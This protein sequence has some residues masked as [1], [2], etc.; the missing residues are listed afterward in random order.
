MIADCGFGRE[1]VAE[2]AQPAMESLAVLPQV[3]ALVAACISLR[4]EVAAVA[5]TLGGKRR[6]EDI[7]AADEAQHLE[8][9]MVR[10][11]EAADRADRLG[12]GADDEVDIALAAHFL[13]HAAA[14]GAEEAHAMRFVAQDHRAML[15]G[16]RDH[17]RQRRDVAEH[18]IDAFEHD[19]LAG[20]L[21]Q[22]AEALVEILDAVVAEADDLGIAEPAA[23][24]DRR[25]AVGVEDDVIALAGKR[26]DHAEIGLVAGRKDDRRFGAVKFLQRI[27]DN[28]DADRRCR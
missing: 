27:L 8:I 16:D 13:I 4:I 2:L 28:R 23:V 15:L 25:V 1:R 9:G 21:G 7:G 20:L 24:I 18:R 22:A 26:G 11:A 14:V 3:R 12:E 10:H 19:Q 6:G 5:T 17:F